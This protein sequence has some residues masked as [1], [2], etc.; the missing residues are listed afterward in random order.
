MVVMSGLPASGEREQG[1]QDWNSGSHGAA[2]GGRASCRNK[3]ASYIACM[4]PVRTL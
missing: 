1:G 2:L 4:T 3:N